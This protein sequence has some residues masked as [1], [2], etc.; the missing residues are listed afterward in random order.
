MRS[1][2][3]F[4]PGTTSGPPMPQRR[5]RGLVARE[6]RRPL[7]LHR[8]REPREVVV[9]ALAAA[10]VLERRARRLGDRGR[11][12][13]ACTA[14]A[15]SPAARTTGTRDGAWSPRPSA[16]L[17][18]NAICVEKKR[19]V[20]RLD[21]LRLVAERLRRVRGLDRLDLQRPSR[22]RS[23]LMRDLDAAALAAEAHVR[24][25][26]PGRRVLREPLLPHAV[27]AVRSRAG[28]RCRRSP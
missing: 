6:V 13:R 8:L 1:S 18:S 28:G 5:R 19:N 16:P 23:S 22:W 14:S 17:E 12:C 27:H 21:R 11:R 2:R 25:H 26:H 10:E 3:K 4:A 24:D 20:A 9:E 7:V 15:P